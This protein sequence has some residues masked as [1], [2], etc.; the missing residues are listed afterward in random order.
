ME[1]IESEW[2]LPE[3]KLVLRVAHHQI[4]STLT[5]TQIIFSIEKSGV[6][7]WNR[8]DWKPFKFDRKKGTNNNNNNIASLRLMSLKLVQIVWS[9]IVN[10]FVFA[11]IHVHLQCY[12]R[13]RD[14]RK[15]KG[16]KKEK[17]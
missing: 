8:N 2:K 9:L 15:E 1:S 11:A 4:E 10:F 13:C 12:R 5:H 14:K 16:A 7:F 3:I 17:M 6:F